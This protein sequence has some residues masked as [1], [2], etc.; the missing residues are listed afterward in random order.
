M[1]NAA[2]VPPPENGPRSCVVGTDVHQEA[3]CWR[4]R[5]FPP[6][7]ERFLLILL[8]LPFPSCYPSLQSF[9]L[10][11][12]TFLSLSRELPL[13]QRLL[14]YC[15]LIFFGFSHFPSH[16]TCVLSHRFGGVEYYLLF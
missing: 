9:S 6:S 2:P 4:A 8:S 1:P 15:I 14:D 7:I 10:F 3:V 12:F 16:I 13:G 11:P 5:G